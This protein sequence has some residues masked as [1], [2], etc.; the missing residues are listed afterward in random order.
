MKQKWLRWCK[1]VGVEGVSRRISE[2]EETAENIGTDAT[3]GLLGR[4]MGNKGSR[5]T[6]KGIK[7]FFGALIVRGIFEGARVSVNTALSNTS[8]E[9]VFPIE[10]SEAFRPTDGWEPTATSTGNIFKYDT[11]I[12]KGGKAPPKFDATREGFKEPKDVKEKEKEDDIN[13]IYLDDIP[14][15][16]GVMVGYNYELI[17]DDEL[18]KDDNPK[19]R[20]IGFEYSKMPLEKQL[21][22]I[23]R[24]T[25]PQISKPPGFIERVSS[26]GETIYLDTTRDDVNRGKQ[27]T[28]NSISLNLPE[29]VVEEGS[30]KGKDFKVPHGNGTDKQVAT[31]GGKKFKRKKTRRKKRKGGRKKTRRKRKR[32]KTRKKRKKV[33]RKKTRRKR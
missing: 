4:D 17:E 30:V 23:R 32:K 27:R 31:K 6:V 13:T 14:D 21:A 26:T 15:K 28:S 1:R 2:M 12:P 24:K 10:F 16:E 9:Q 11:R 20:I 5:W 25:D 22:D 33:R 3:T 19:Y 29:D 8:Q 18:E 7:Y